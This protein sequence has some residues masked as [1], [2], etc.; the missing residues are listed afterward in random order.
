MKKA[1]RRHKS[2]L[3]LLFLWALA[4]ACCYAQ[5][6]TL[7]SPPLYALGG[8]RLVLR[9]PQGWKIVRRD[10][11]ARWR[12]VSFDLAISPTRPGR[13]TP[14]AL[15][16]VGRDSIGVE[17]LQYDV[18][19]ARTHGDLRGRWL[20]AVSGLQGRVHRAASSPTRTDWY[21]AI[22]IG[23]PRAVLIVRLVGLAGTEKAQ[24]EFAFQVFRSVRFI[25]TNGCQQKA[26]LFGSSTRLLAGECGPARR[27]EAHI[28]ESPRWVLRPGSARLFDAPR[29]GGAPRAATS[30]ST[31]SRTRGC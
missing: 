24:R 30:G 26:R 8:K 28:T 31:A 11:A 1:Q 10:E 3:L 6:G 20:T 14:S 7:H 2:H 23:H 4:S 13:A 12:S 22:A 16:G 18:T 29:S 19:R 9:L 27:T 17:V 15:I 5:A 25:R 21:F